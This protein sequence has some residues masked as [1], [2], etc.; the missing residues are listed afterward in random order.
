MV[1]SASI[2]RVALQLAHLFA[3]SRNFTFEVLKSCH[4]FFSL[5]VRCSSFTE[6]RKARCKID[7]ARYSP[8]VTSGSAKRT[9]PVD[10]YENHPLF[11]Y[12]NLNERPLCQRQSGC[13]EIRPKRLRKFPKSH[14][15]LYPPILD[16]CFHRSPFAGQ[17]S[18]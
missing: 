3:K 17:G 5:R 11:V 18:P 6:I 2:A 4:R 7:F 16:Y 12:R 10:G 8:D 15:G 1:V 14:T 9:K 13:G